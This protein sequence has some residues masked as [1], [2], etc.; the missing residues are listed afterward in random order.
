VK[1][2]P[3][4]ETLLPVTLL[5]SVL[6]RGLDELSLQ[7]FRLQEYSGGYLLN[8]RILSILDQRPAETFYVIMCDRGWR[9]QEA[10]VGV[11]NGE[12][13]SQFQ[14]RRDEQNQWFRDGERISS[15]DGMVDIDLSISPA[16]NTLPIRRLALEIGESRAVDAAWMR[17]PELTL[18]RLEQRYTRLDARRYR[19]ESGGGSFTAEIEVDDNGVV[20]RYSDLWER[21]APP[22]RK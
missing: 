17:F 4:G 7:H 18:E 5:A 9:T 19:Y 11:I 1:T 8:G 21:V 12:E 2:E 22:L 6:W 10:H 13:T 3:I 14:I 15:L 16:T 20:A